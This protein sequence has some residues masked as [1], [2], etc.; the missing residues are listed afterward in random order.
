MMR[1][2]R[3]YRKPDSLLL[4]V[5]AVALGAVMSSAV[6]AG[7]LINY[8]PTDSGT[9]LTALFLDNGY[10]PDPA[11]PASRL[12]VSFTPPPVA[13][14]AS[15]AGHDSLKPSHILLTWRVRW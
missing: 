3:H 15:S 13:T 12:Q 7:E 8:R 1:N 10:V 14:A 6:N 9:R 4:L 11:N 2:R 5:A